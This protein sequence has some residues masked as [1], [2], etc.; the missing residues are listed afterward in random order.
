MTL[1]DVNAAIRKHLQ[2]DNLAVVL[3]TQQAAELEK[4]LTSGEP[5]PLV[6][7]TGGTPADIIAEDKIIAS[8]P[9]KIGSIKTVPVERLF[10][11]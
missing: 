11:K 1:D 8:W 7:D 6:Y 5:T 4:Q 3:V 2:A 9:L 10:E